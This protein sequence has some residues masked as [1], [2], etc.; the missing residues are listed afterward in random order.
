MCRIS[1]HSVSSFASLLSSLS[2]F[3]LKTNILHLSLFLLKSK[4]FKFIWKKLLFLQC[5]GLWF[6]NFS[7][8]L[9]NIPWLMR[10]WLQNY[11]LI[12]YCCWFFF[13]FFK[14]NFFKVSVSQNI[15]IVIASSIVSTSS[16]YFWISSMPFLFKA[17]WGS[18]SSNSSGSEP[19]YNRLLFLD[20]LEMKDEDK[21]KQTNKQ[22]ETDCNELNWES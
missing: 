11:A 13:F 16:S 18:N 15:L 20:I 1:R 4:R 9:S 5:H 14:V 19:E 8:L 3:F 7:K 21:N 2:S 10:K 6:S 22:T 17:N 12:G